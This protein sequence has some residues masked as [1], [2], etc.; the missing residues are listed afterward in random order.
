MSDQL[1]VGLD[2]EELR[3][4]IEATAAMEMADIDATFGRLS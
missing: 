2:K 1:A 3:A 4:L